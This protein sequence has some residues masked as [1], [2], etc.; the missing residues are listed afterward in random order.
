MVNSMDERVEGVVEGNTEDAFNQN[1]QIIERL[2]Q[3]SGV[4]SDREL[5]KI[6]G[7]Q[8]Q[9]VT[10]AKKR[11]IP[12]KWIL[13][14][15]NQFD[16]SANYLLTGEERGTER[17]KDNASFMNKGN[18]TE[19]GNKFGDMSAEEW[20]ILGKAYRILTSGTEYKSTLLQNINALYD[21]LSYRHENETLKM[22][23]QLLD[24]VNKSNKSNIS[25]GIEEEDQNRSAS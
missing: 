19:Y 25:K 15:S 2:K 18:K 21:L 1:K 14:I 24:K 6:L 22:R 16:C 11:R 9:N 7:I 23:I 3:A 13:A 5:A 8:P 4:K 10:T 20:E 12:E 17:I